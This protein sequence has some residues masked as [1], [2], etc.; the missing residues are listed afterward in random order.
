MKTFRS[1]FVIGITVALWCQGCNK[2]LDLTPISNTVVGDG[3]QGTAGSSITN[4]ASAEAALASSYGIFRSGSSEYYVMDYFLIGEAQSDNAHAGADNPNMFEMDEFRMLSTNALAA[5]DWSYL[6]NHISSTN[7]I[8]ANVPNVSDLNETRRNQI[9]G[10]ALFMR[11]RAYF[12]LVR[13]YGDV[14]LVV[15]ELPTVTNDNLEEIFSLLYPERTPA[16]EVYARII[17]DLEAAA[18]M[19]PTSGPDKMTVTPGAVYTLLAKIYAT[20]QPTDWSKV[21]EYC[22]RVIGLGYNLVD[23]YEHLWD[24]EHEN[25]VESIFELNF[26]DWDTGGNWGTGMFYG[27]DWKKFNVP[28]YDLIQA[29][30]EE[31]DEV[32]K[33]STIR[34]ENVSSLWSDPH[35]RNSLNQYPFAY[36]MRK[37]GGDQNIIIYRLADV[38]LLKA[39]ALNEASA[40]GWSA[41][42]LL[43]DEV[44]NRVDLGG[45]PASDQVSMRLAIENERRLELAFEGHR[46]FDL[47]RTGRAIEVMR[48]QVGAD[49]NNLN[50]GIDEDRLIWPIPLTQIDL[51]ENLIQN[52]GY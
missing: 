7:S 50:Y 31:N 10:E 8:I 49:G 45:T 28:S 21:L 33:A 6:Y 32:R 29:F 12:D 14:P 39:E 16:S 4:A 52:P 36:K 48:A 40:S 5:R 22:D 17:A 47:V 34:Y 35:W 24:G 25:T 51:N 19:V 44:R 15:D 38:L 11:A 30:D 2:Q 41:A 13:L 43:V 20:Q 26:T 18:T 42:K 23:Q 37:T 1:L 9:V 27:L 3:G 46:W